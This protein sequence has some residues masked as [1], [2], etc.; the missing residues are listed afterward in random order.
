M[1]LNLLTS[2]DSTGYGHAGRSIL[3]QLTNAGVCVA[4][5]PFDF[6]VHVSRDP[7]DPVRLGLAHAGRYDPAAPSV[8]ICMARKLAEHVGRGTHAGFPFF[9]LDRF[10]SDE[11]HHLSHQD[12]ILVASSWAAAIVAANGI[13]APTAVV[14]LGVDRSIFHES[15]NAAGEREPAAG[16]TVFVNI[17][18]WER[19]KGHD[20][21]L[22][23]LCKAFTPRDNIIVTLLCNNYAT[24]QEA[25]DE[26]AR[27]FLNSAVGTKVRLVPRLQSQQNVAVLV[28]G[29]DCG[30]FPSRAEAWNL[31]LLECM[32]AGLSVIATAYS[33]HTEFANQVNCRLIHIDETE[34]AD[35]DPRFW[36]QGR[37]AKL[38]PS[39]ME[40][41]VHH[42]RE[43]HRLKQEGALDRNDAGIATARAF[44]WQRT[45]DALLT[46]IR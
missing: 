10:D 12:V 5:F 25:N 8:R 2:L 24:T 4:L 17:G 23:A 41:L 37:W 31:G 30:V 20:F 22:E 15:R 27:A 29:C 40:Q 13:T 7:K 28:S 39:Q 38:G 32:S 45:V 26:W 11:I 19:R 43:V 34:P 44:S 36:G 42:L 16:P 46:A 3:E 14:P 35:A 9:E 33:G 21:L 1:N 18:K 6:S